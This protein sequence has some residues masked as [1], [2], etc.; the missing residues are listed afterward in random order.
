MR[1]FDH[2]TRIAINHAAHRT[3][4]GEALNKGHVSV[5]ALV[6]LIWPALN[7]VAEQS[8]A[9]NKTPTAESVV[10]DMVEF[11]ASEARRLKAEQDAVDAKARADAQGLADSKAAADKAGTPVGAQ[12]LPE[13]GV[14]VGKIGQAQKPAA[15]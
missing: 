4:H 13:Q 14:A 3:P 9:E 8:L 7:H 1:A 15:V 12:L 11:H 10:A 2:G 5:G 6:E